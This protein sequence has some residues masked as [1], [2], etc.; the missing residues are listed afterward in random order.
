MTTSRSPSRQPSSAWRDASTTSRS[1]AWSAGTSRTTPSCATRADSPGFPRT[2][3]CPARFWASTATTCRSPSSLTSTTRTGSSSAKRSRGIELANVGDATQR[4]VQA[5]RRSRA[6]RHEEFGDLLAE[7]LFSLIGEILDRPVDE[8]DDRI[9]RL[10]SQLFEFATEEFWAD[11][12]RA[13]R[14]D[15]AGNP[16]RSRSA[17]HRRGATGAA[18]VVGGRAATEHDHART[19]RGFPRRVAGRPRRLGNRRRV[20]QQRQQH[21][22]KR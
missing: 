19:V 9:D 17:R 11:F 4:P 3:S 21:A 15:A 20:D 7:G 10:P 1:R 12:I 6:S 22:G 13:R 14:A 18:V 2:T 16:A 5:L 8:E